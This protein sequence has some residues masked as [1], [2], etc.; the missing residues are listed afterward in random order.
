MKYW[1]P[2]A[3]FVT[4]L[5]FISV[6]SNLY[7]NYGIIKLDKKL[8]TKVFNDYD[9]DILLI[10]FGYV[11]CIDVC[12]PRMTEIA[13]IY[14]RIKKKKSVRPVF[15][16]LI[17]LKDIKLAQ[18][19]ASAFNKDYKALKI[20]KSELNSLKNEFNV[21]STPSLSS[22]TDLNH[23]SFLFL[24]KKEKGEYHLRRIYVNTPFKENIILQ[25]IRKII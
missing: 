6:G 17:E 12:T 1:L 18:E 13:G 8:E 5:L 2:P 21:Y 16:N 14:D 10:F 15:V 19:F 3:I 9:E 7:T 20:S 23:T 25:D 11:G 24:L 22:K 4:I